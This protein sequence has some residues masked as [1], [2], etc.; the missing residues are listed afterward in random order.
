MKAV[1]VKKVLIANSNSFWS[2]SVYSQ[3]PIKKDIIWQCN[4][5]PQDIRNQ[6]GQS[7]WMD[8]WKAWAKFNFHHPET[9][10][11]IL[12]QILWLNSHMKFKKKLLLNNILIDRQ[13]LYIRDLFNE[14]AKQ[15]LSFEEFTQNNGRIIDFITYNRIIRCIPERWKDVLINQPFIPYEFA[16]YKNNIEYLI[17]N[18]TPSQMVYSRLLLEG[19]SA[20]R[21]YV[22]QT[23]AGEL[24]LAGFD[25]NAWFTSCAQVMRISNCT[26]LRY[27]QYRLLHRFLT[28]NWTRS[29]WDLTQDPACSLCK[30]NCETIVHLFWECP[31]SGGLWKT[32]LRWLKYICKLDIKDNVT[33]DVM[34]FNNFKG[35][36]QWLVNTI[37][38]I[39][40]QYI[41][42]Q[43][44]LDKELNFLQL[45][46]A[47]ARYE[48]L[49]RAIACKNNTQKKHNRKWGA[50]LAIYK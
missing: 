42:A 16:N 28:T 5:A 3:L 39:T 49:E 50:Y 13:V 34:I 10:P 22:P 17:Q 15:F 36:Q 48:K 41:Y 30:Q 47:V 26:K 33:L 27:F 23:W 20:K 11:E 43:K 19:S 6:F 35:P 4:T 31:K 44:C 46:Q 24:G 25:D 40:K 12:D 21:D 8:T 29:R 45:M 37:L 18:K 7:L 1:W 38:L 32:M 9:A 2:K 14:N